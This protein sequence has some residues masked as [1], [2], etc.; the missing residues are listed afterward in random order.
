MNQTPST[1]LPSRFED[2]SNLFYLMVAIPLLAFIWIYLNLQA[3]RPWGYFADPDYAIY[4]NAAMLLLALSLGVLAFVQY[5]RRFEGLEPE[6]DK[7]HGKEEGVRERLVFKFRTFKSASL[8]KY[9]L[10]TTCSLLVVVGYYLSAEA[11]YGAF[12]G[13]MIVIFSLHRPTPERF[14]RDMRLSK[15]ERQALREILRQ[16]RGQEQQ[17]DKK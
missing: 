8:Q 11:Y 14:I 6:A 15:E 3:I 4:V 9:L 12:Y 16:G 17:E 5:R 10:L 13:L 1:S 2:L 7:A